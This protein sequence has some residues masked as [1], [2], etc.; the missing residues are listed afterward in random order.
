MVRED[1][2]RQRRVPAVSSDDLPTCQHPDNPAALRHVITSLSLSLLCDSLLLSLSHSMLLPSL[3]L[4]RFPWRST[5]PFLTEQSDRGSQRQKQRV[6]GVEWWFSHG[7]ELRKKRFWFFFSDQ[8]FYWEGWEVKLRIRGFTQRT[9]ATTSFQKKQVMVPPLQY[10]ERF[11][12][13]PMKSSRLSAWISI[14]AI[15]IWFAFFF[16]TLSLSLSML[17]FFFFFF[18]VWKFLVL[19]FGF[20]EIRFEV[21][22]C[23]VTVIRF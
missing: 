5:I 11:I 13:L 10:T 21:R 2:P 8:Q 6:Q 22:S 15:V 9:L 3:S 23:L 14:A 1:E 12:F 20:C 16:L 4:Q 19:L 17:Q 7:A 18:F